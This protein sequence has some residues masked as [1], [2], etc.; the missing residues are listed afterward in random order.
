MERP[1]VQAVDRR[2]RRAGEAG[3]RRRAL[4]RPLVDCAAG[5]RGRGPTHRAAVRDDALAK[6]CMGVKRHPRSNER[7][8]SERTRKLAWA[9]VIVA[10][11]TGLSRVAG[12]GREVLVA[13]VYGVDPQYNTLI[14]VSVLYC[15][16][17]P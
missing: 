15:G 9:A 11:A 4:A 3:G 7:G 2:G 12:L 8:M 16:S 6:R 13:A 1:G 17:T 5:V 10:A 14:S